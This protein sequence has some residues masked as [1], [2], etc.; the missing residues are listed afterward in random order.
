MEQE[1]TTSESSEAG[2]GVQQLVRPREGRVLAGVSQALANRFGLPNWVPRAFFVVT[3]F[4]GGLGLALYAAGWA[5][6][7]SEDE[8]ESPAERFFDGASSTKSWIGIGL[9]FRGRSHSPREPHVLL[10]RGCV[11]RRTSDCGCLALFGAHSPGIKQ[12]QIKGRSST[13]DNHQHL[14]T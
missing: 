4:F 7:R 1:T 12:W 13:D 2:A 10:R 11:R 3:A 14:G 5:L 8:A 9:I 6:V